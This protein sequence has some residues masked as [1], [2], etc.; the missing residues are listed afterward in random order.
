[1]GKKGPLAIV[2]PADF[3]ERTALTLSGRSGSTLALDRAYDA[4]H[5]ARS[6]DNAR[7]LYDRLR[8]YLQAHGGFWNKCERNVVSGGLLEYL[9]NTVRP[10]GLTPAQAAEMDRKA[11]ARIREVE[12]PSARFG[13]LYFLANIKLEVDPF[14]A[15]VDGAAH[16]GG[17]IGVGMTTDFGKTADAASAVRDVAR[18]GGIG[19]KAAHAA[20]GGKAVMH[21]TK[22]V[23]EKLMAPS[24]GAAKNALPTTEAALRMLARSISDNYHADRY[25]RVAGAVVLAAPV[26]AVALVVDGARYVWDKVRA[27]MAKIGDMLQRAWQRK[28]DLDTAQKLGAL[29]KMGSKVAVDM[30]MKNAVPYIGGA[31]DLGTGIARALGEACTRVASW[32]DRR[33]IDLQDGHPTQIASAIESQMEKGIFRGLAEAL[34]GAAKMAVGIFL[35]GLGS[36][37]SVL[38]G[39][40]EWLVRMVSR[41]AEQTA[42][43]NFLRRARSAYAA[44][45]QR[46]K[47]VDGVY[48]PSTAPGGLINDTRRFADF[49]QAGC[50][51]SPLIPMLALNCGLGGGPMTLIKLF[52]SDGNPTL[53]A[54][55]GRQ[56]LTADTYFTR[57]KRHGVEYMRVSGFKFM[58]LKSSDGLMQG[59]LT[60]ATGMGKSVQSHVAGGSVL[61]RVAAFAQA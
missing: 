53:K 38:M 55:A 5:G 48:E 49:F 16:V 15:V 8:D 24:S 52:E 17:A 40:I 33:Q 26:T 57:L 23:V 54:D 58:P 2:S 11:A 60:H 45:Q 51:A 61:G 14:T 29:I 30:I 4:Y 47:L 10:G 50:K 37:V 22:L 6:P 28:G 7:Q 1:M 12:I 13:V 36:L 56:L 3:R 41:F 27:A 39:A 34:I 32:H 35:P 9:Y 18:V 42:I 25:R 59:Y 20:I 43:G 46:A 21:G 44:E 19:V 31:I